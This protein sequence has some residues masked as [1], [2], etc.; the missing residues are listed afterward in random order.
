ML[1]TLPELRLIGL[2]KV[3]GIVLGCMNMEEV[4][5]EKFRTLVENMPD[6]ASGLGGA[7]DFEMFWKILDLYVHRTAGPS[8]EARALLKGREAIFQASNTW[9]NLLAPFMSPVAW[10]ATCLEAQGDDTLADS[11]AE[12]SLNCWPK[13]SSIVRCGHLA[14]RSRV[15]ARY[16]GRGNAMEFARAAVQVAVEEHVPLMAVLT[17]REFGEDG[18]MFIEDGCKKMGRP[19]DVVLQELAIA[20]ADGPEQPPPKS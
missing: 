15:A 5:T 10:A 3:A 12:T 7:E 8:D 13:G 2:D 14:L 1:H 18:L 4:G 17:G 20:R 6:L 11:F 16:G 19:L 9:H